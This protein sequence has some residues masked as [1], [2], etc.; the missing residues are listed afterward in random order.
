MLRPADPDGMH[1]AWRALEATWATT[2]ERAG[3]LT[4]EQRHES[5]GGEWSLVA[6]L[7]HL[8]MAMDKWFTVP[9]LGEAQ[10]HPIGLPNAG[11]TDFGF[12]DL[13]PA[14][15]PSFDEVL[16]VRR[17]RAL[18]VRRVPRPAAAGRAQP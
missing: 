6:T 12:P 10:F 2:I 9:I 15:D 8:V 1:D 14:A 11:S 7:R 18:R 16:S 17:Q 13:D 4:E 5:V 3:R